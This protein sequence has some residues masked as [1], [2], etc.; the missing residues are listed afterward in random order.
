[1]EG[2]KSVERGGVRTWFVGGGE[3]SLLEGTRGASLFE[4]VLV[5][6][7]DGYQGRGG[8]ARRAVTCRQ[9]DERRRQR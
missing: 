9:P 8:L 6:A 4:Y 2:K 3:E 7:D 1:M 5:G